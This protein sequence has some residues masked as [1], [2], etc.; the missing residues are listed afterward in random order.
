MTEEL[1]PKRRP[2]MMPDE[3]AKAM[4]E[5]RSSPDFVSPMRMPE[6]EL[7]VAKEPELFNKEDE[8]RLIREASEIFKE[9][10]VEKVEPPVWVPR[11]SHFIDVQGG[12]KYLPARR[13]VQ[14]MRQEPQPHPDWTIDTSLQRLDQGTF[15]SRNKI[16]GGYAVFE[17][18]IKDRKGRIIAT[19]HAAEYSENF[20][21]FLE[22][23]ETSAVARALALAGYGTESALDLEEGFIA[24]SPFKRDGSMGGDIRIEGASVEGVIQGGRSENVT[25]PQLA[26]IRRLAR[27]LDLDPADLATLVTSVT[28]KEYDMSAMENAERIS[29]VLSVVKE[30]SFGDAAE[31]IGLLK[32]AG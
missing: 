22:K 27:E 16:V 10:A 11:D 8:L 14:W 32:A 1:R 13:R 18:Q 7:P 12:A 19:G 3:A 6:T 25:G 17:A 5:L 9:V 4:E 15:Q 24:D 2:R 31:V 29:F 30:L 26:E 23:A 28:G 21:D 20:F